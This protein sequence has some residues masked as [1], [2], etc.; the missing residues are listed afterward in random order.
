MCVCVYM[1]V[2]VYIRVS[3]CEG[4]EGGGYR[5]VSELAGRG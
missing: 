3:I 1:C 2:V 4:G 5:G